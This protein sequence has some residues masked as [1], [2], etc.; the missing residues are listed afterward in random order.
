VP[1][2]PI[3]LAANLQHFSGKPWAATTVVSLPQNTQQR[4]LL[5]ERGTRRLSSQT[6]LD[7]RVSTT[8]RFG[9]SRRIDLLVDVLNALNE[10]AEEALVSD[11]LF[12]STFGSGTSFVDPRRVMF[13]V[14]LKLGE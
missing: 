6:L 14:R 10:D 1:R 9:S 11:N 8:L 7:V 5:E 13:G 3:E 2:T 4:V 12:A